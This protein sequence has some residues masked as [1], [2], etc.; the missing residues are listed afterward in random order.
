MFS[1]FCDMYGLMLGVLTL[2]LLISDLSCMVSC[3]V[4][5][6]E[7]RSCTGRRT[8]I[9]VRSSSLKKKGSGEAFC[10]MARKTFGTRLSG[11]R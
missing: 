5:A 2:F 8:R 3:T 7:P 11:P 1:M 10:R 6:R 9:Q 4:T